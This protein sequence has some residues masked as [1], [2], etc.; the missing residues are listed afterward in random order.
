MHLEVKY[1]P[2]DHVFTWT[3]HQSAG[4]N[5]PEIVECIVDSVQCSDNHNYVEY[6]LVNA[7]TYDFVAITLESRMYDSREEAEKQRENI[8]SIW[9]R[10]RI[11]CAE[12]KVEESVYD[13]DEALTRLGDIDKEA[14]NKWF[15]R[16]FL[17]IANEMKEVNCPTVDLGGDGEPRK[18]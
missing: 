14:L 2:G 15:G 13:L 12:R 17:R 5:P 16:L 4:S 8:I 18:Y 6:K 1:L 10:W 11:S 3:D 7:E 9:K